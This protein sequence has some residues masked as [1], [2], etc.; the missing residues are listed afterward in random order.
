MKINLK[1]KPFNLN[2]DDIKWVENTLGTMTEEEKIA[3]LF[4]LIAYSSEENYLDYLSCGLKIGDARSGSCK[5]GFP[6]TGAFKNP[7]AYFCK[8]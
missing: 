8:S 2:D 4:C 1:A 5:N 6:L 7:N 3:Q